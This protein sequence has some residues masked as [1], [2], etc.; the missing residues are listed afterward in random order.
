[1]SYVM[2]V[3]AFDL[4][5]MKHNAIWFLPSFLPILSN[6]L[7]WYASCVLPTWCSSLGITQTSLSPCPLWLIFSH[8]SSFCFQ[9]RCHILVYIYRESFL[10]IMSFKYQAHF[11]IYSSSVGTGYPIIAILPRLRP[12]FHYMYLT[13]Q[14]H[15]FLCFWR[16]IA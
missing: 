8:L 15:Y 3:S 6:E 9:L 10:A 4:T 5:V 2:W 13:C 1:M 12:L 7:L 14:G 16:G 11:N